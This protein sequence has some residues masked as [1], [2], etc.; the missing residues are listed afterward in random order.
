MNQSFDDGKALG[1]VRLVPCTYLEI[2]VRLEFWG[3]FAER[4]A[5]T[6]TELQL[7]FA[8]C[9]IAVGETLLTEVVD[10]RQDFLKPVDAACEFFEQGGFW[11][12]SL[13]L[14]CACSCHGRTKSLT[15]GYEPSKKTTGLRPR[16]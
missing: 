15:E 11:S 1:C 2:P 14:S 5:Q 16:P 4:L 6:F 3:P 9:R 12:R 7:G 8:L 13:L 10:R